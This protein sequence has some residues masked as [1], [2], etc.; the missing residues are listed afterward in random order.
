MLQILFE[1]L[2]AVMRLLQDINWQRVKTLP[3]L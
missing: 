3:E 1:Q 2:I